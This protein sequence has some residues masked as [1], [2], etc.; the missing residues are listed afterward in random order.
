MSKKKE[1]ENKVTTKH[2]KLDKMKLTKKFDK[3]HKDDEEIKALKKHLKNKGFEPKDDEKNYHG[4]ESTHEKDDKKATVSLVIQD[5]AKS[6][7]K[8]GAC[9]GQVA[10]RSDDRTE[11]Y[12]FSLIAPEGDYKKVK[13]HK[14]NKKNLEVEEAECFWSCV[15]DYLLKHFVGDV[16]AH[17]NSCRDASWIWI[18][19]SWSI[20][21]TCISVKFGILYTLA[22]ACCGCN[23]GW[24]C[25]WISGCCHQ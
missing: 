6:K 14:V 4:F 12:S 21:L 5:Y 10:I 20:F 7:G 8:D 15:L 18:F 11:V 23:C 19:F 16:W 3:L 25:N 2:E 9:V 1:K 22:S 13:E 24:W 17:V